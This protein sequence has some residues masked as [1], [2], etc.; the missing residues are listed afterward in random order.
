MTPAVLEFDVYSRYEL[1]KASLIPSG[2]AVISTFVKPITNSSQK[3][4]KH[5]IRNNR[6]ANLNCTRS[7][8]TRSSFFR[9][10]KAQGQRMN[11][12]RRAMPP[13]AWLSLGGQK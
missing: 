10:F 2:L 6:R 3:Y 13:Y 5:S 8:Q 7:V 9:F 4:N 12:I 11:Q 1:V